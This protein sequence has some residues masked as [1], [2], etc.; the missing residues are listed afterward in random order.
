MSNPI[1]QKINGEICNLSPEAMRQQVNLQLR[2]KEAQK[3][4][5]LLSLAMT[6]YEAVKFVE[7][8]I[9]KQIKANGSKPR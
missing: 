1:K 2:T 7:N 9:I 8:S 6:N 3:A 4:R 5:R